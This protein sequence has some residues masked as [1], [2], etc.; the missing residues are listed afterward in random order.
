MALSMGVAG[1]TSK[2]PCVW[3]FYETDEFKNFRG[4]VEEYIHINNHSIH[5]RDN[6]L[7]QQ[8]NQNRIFKL[9]FL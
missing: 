8:Q 1:A 3:C 7:T 6:N 9:L 4:T 2:H 5:D